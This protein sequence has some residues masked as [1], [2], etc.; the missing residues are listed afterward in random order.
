MELMP[1]FETERD[2]EDFFKHDREIVDKYRG[3]DG[4]PHFKDNQEFENLMRELMPEY[5]H[6]FIY[7]D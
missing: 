3:E 5:K 6:S 1:T 7:E 2:F 4:V